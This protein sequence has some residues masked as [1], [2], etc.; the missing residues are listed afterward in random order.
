VSGYSE[1]VVKTRELIGSDFNFIHKPFQL[2]DVVMKVR[3]TLD[4]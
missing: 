1:D 3:E 4:K 2:K